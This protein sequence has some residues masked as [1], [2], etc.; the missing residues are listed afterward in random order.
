[1][2]DLADKLDI[3]PHIYAPLAQAPP[4]QYA[5]AARPDLPPLVRAGVLTYHLTTDERETLIARYRLPKDAAR[6]LR[7]VG[8]LHE[9]VADLCQPQMSNSQLDRLLQPY[10]HPALDVVRYIHTNVVSDRITHYLANLRPAAPLLDGHAL[11]RLGVPP[12]KRLGA[13]LRDLRAARLDGLVQTQE[14]EAAWV[15]QQLLIDE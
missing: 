12:G 5:L 11:Q 14:D 4:T 6:V 9:L 10:G 1:V 2:L 13:L 3:T 8:R 15:Q 7:E